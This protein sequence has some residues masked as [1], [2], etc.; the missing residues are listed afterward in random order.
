MDVTLP[1]L[2]A[3]ELGIQSQNLKS[4]CDVLN[5]I[6]LSLRSVCAN[7]RL[8]TEVDIESP[9]KSR[10]RIWSSKSVPIVFPR[11]NAK[12]LLKR[13]WLTKP[14][15]NL[16]QHMQNCT[17]TWNKTQTGLTATPGSLGSTRTRSCEYT[18]LHTPH[19]EGYWILSWPTWGE[20][21]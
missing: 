8:N 15:W 12:R 2:S 4:A 20:I 19:N 1:I 21:D 14:H 17:L 18:E 13:N 9:M 11:Q 5:W 6:Q 10:M 16:Y 7:T 3:T